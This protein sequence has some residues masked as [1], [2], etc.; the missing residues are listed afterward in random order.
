MT[1]FRQSIRKEKSTQEPQTW[2]KYRTKTSESW[3]NIALLIPSIQINNETGLWRINKQKYKAEKTTSSR[4]KG[5]SIFVSYSEATVLFSLRPT[6]WEV[7][8]QVGVLLTPI[9]KNEGS[10]PLCVFLYWSLHSVSSLHDV[11]TQ[12]IWFC[13]K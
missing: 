6:F 8:I 3:K 13:S 7:S 12:D 5:H 10:F 1:Y 4:S 9:G 2:T 11:Q